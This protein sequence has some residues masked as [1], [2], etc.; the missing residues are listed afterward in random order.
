[1]RA[2]FAP[3]ASR[4]ERG[5][6]RRVRIE[7][8]APTGE[9]IAR[10]SEGVGFI[11]RALPGELVETTLYEVRKKFWRGSLRRVLEPSA[12]RVGGPHADCAG[13]DWAHFEPGAA[14]AAKRELFRETMRRIGK[15]PPE[16]FGELPMAASAP[17]Y[18]LRARLHV[19]GRERSAALGYFAPGTHRVVPAATC[20]ALS[21]DTRALLSAARQAIADSGAVVSE[22]AMLEDVEGGRRLVRA[23]AA[24]EPR[25]AARLAL[26]LEELFEGVRVAPG[27]G[28]ALVERG[29]RWL[30]L[31]VGGRT[32]TVSVDTFFQGN[33]F[34][35]SALSA[36]VAGAASTDTRGSALDAFGGAGLFAGPLL[37]AGYRVHS[38]EADPGAVADARRTRESWP[39]RDRWE[40]AGVPVEQFLEDTDDRFD[41]VVADPP[42]AGLG[43]N[44]ASSLARCAAGRLIYVSCDPATLA[45]DL[46]AILAEGFAI[47]HAALYDLFPFTHRVEAMIGLERAA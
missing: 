32:H 12:D 46:T 2:P 6:G 7:K 10:T 25:E 23:T 40:I 9:G 13:C 30:G 37:S 4:G 8:L 47:R 42:R 11:D 33:R 35:V 24:A 31:T 15:L 22:I 27:E 36:G 41:C 1:M 14:R 44:L 5:E 20:E 43:P 17:G 39:D 21:S 3:A 18:R 38:V 19:A 26:S 16:I 28:P 34:L 29:D 45:R